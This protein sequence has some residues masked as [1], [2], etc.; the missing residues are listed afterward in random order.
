MGFSNILDLATTTAE[1]NTEP[2]I[3]WRGKGSV[4]HL[5]AG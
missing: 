1:T 2:T 5:V 4:S 3:W